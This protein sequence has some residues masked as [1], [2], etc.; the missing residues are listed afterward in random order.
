[1]K[2]G[3]ATSASS[4]A[5]DWMKMN[6][7]SIVQPKRPSTVSASAPASTTSSDV[8]ALDCAYKLQEYAGLPRRKR[9][10]GKATWPG[11]KQVWRQ[12]DPD[13]GM[14]QDILSEDGDE[15]AGEP[16]IRAVMKNGRRLLPQPT[17][18]DI[19]ARAARD[20]ERL[21]EPLRRLEPS[22]S[23]PVHVTEG[24]VRLAAEVDGRLAR[25]AEERQP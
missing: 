24:L 23:Y 20:M 14:R 10:T 4:R 3:W 6:S 2:A 25:L 19:R 1:M 11:R 15:Q 7:R 17:L 9:S 13:G 18:A 12:Y 5:A 21:P 8:P 22:T 16:L